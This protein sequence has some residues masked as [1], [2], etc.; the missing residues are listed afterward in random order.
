[1][2]N[3]NND[4]PKKQKPSK[5][6]KAV[7]KYDSLD[8]RFR[9]LAKERKQ[10]KMIAENERLKAENKELADKNKKAVQV[11]GVAEAAFDVFGRN[12]PRGR[13]ECAK[14]MR[15]AMNNH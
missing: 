8:E 15:S 5:L 2:L 12:L 7:A 13:E 10:A 6:Q 9:K 1:M 4:S 11:L 3:D 14:A